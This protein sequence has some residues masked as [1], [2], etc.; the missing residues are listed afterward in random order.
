MTIGVRAHTKSNVKI[1]DSHVEVEVE[2][3]GLNI[4]DGA[5]RVALICDEPHINKKH[6]M[7]FSK[8]KRW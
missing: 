3:S 4:T 5:Y 7:A 2:M 8:C 6:W 1:E